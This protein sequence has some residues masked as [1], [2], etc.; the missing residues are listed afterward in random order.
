MAGSVN[1]VILVDDYSGGMSLPE[2]AARHGVSVST[3]RY[4]VKKTGKL[5]SRVDGVRNAADRGRLGSGSSRENTRVQQSAL[6]FYIKGP[7]RVGRRQRQRRFQKE[8]TGT[9]NTRAGQT[10]AVLFT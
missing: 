5:R 6:R 4:H 1:K 9:P 8:K 3:V 2:V 7:A 10:R